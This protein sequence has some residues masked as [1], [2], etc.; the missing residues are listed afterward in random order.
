MIKGIIFDMDG[1]L[2]DSE[3]IY[4]DFEYKLFN[5]LSPEIKKEN[6]IK[7]VG[8]SMDKLVNGLC[9][10][11]N[12]KEPRE[13]IIKKLS[14]EALYLYKADPR[15]ELSKGVID[16]LNYFKDHNYP[17]IIASSTY[18]EK[19]EICIDRFNLKQYFH[20]YIGG[21]DV[22][23][24]K[25]DPEIFLK[26]SS[27]LG[28]IPEECLVIEDSENGIKAAKAAGCLS[29]GYK[30]SNNFQNLSQAD[31]I[32]DSFGKETLPKL[33]SLLLEATKS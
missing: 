11:F 19:I 10:E 24:A 16:W 29:L 17:M 25:P 13:N 28:F 32:F 15:L 4:Q 22:K 9:D 12:I 31:I 7:Y 18:K 33:K 27:K 30:N 14:E 21:S 8:C 26:A 2:V 20:D 23:N 6:I 3:P 1:V 5:S